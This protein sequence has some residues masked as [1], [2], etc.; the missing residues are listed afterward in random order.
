MKNLKEYTMDELKNIAKQLMVSSGT[1]SNARRKANLITPIEEAAEELGMEVP[2]PELD[3]EVR[4]PVKATT[5]KSDKPLRIQDYPRRKVVIESRDPQ[6]KQRT[7]GINTYQA[8]VVFGV[9]SMLPEPVIDYIKTLKD[10][11]HFTKPDGTP[12][13]RF[14]PRFFVTEE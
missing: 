13:R 10:V 14:V 3:I 2:T 8:L 1:I 11:E 12:T 4:Q 5:E 6:W 9:P 7:F